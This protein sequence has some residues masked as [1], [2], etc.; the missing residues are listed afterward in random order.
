[1]SQIT[2]YVFDACLISIAVAVLLIAKFKYKIPIS[3]LD[4]KFLIMGVGFLTVL[5]FFSYLYTDSISQIMTSLNFNLSKADIIYLINSSSVPINGSYIPRQAIANSSLLYSN[6]YFNNSTI[7]NTTLT[8]ST[9]PPL[10]G[11]YFQ[12]LLG[13]VSVILGLATILYAFSFIRFYGLWIFSPES[14][15]YRYFAPLLLLP[16]IFIIF[17][18]PLTVIEIVY[19]RIDTSFWSSI[20]ELVVIFG[21]IFSLYIQN[22]LTGSVSRGFKDYDSIS[23]LLSIDMPGP[24]PV[25]SL[26]L[27]VDYLSNRIYQESRYNHDSLNYNELVLFYYMRRYSESILSL[28]LTII[29]SILIISIILHF[30]LL[31]LLF[32]EICLILIYFVISSIEKIPPGRISV[33]LKDIPADQSN[34]TGVTNPIIGYVYYYASEDLISII[35]PNGRTMSINKDNIL[36]YEDYD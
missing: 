6:A 2:L 22:C 18:L 34:T 10:F 4:A 28:L 24:K 20:F 19:L 36:K 16:N 11:S 30:N 13:V 35:L 5:L 17:I 3:K 9:S 15:Q 27:I 7:I 25:I 29:I 1:M 32:V 8:T 23:T 33:Y 26:S 31:S 12:I 14:K 21:S